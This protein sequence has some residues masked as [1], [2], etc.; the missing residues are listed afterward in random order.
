MQL[1][2]RC[3]GTSFSPHEIHEE[4]PEGELYLR[5]LIVLV[6]GVSRPRLDHQNQHQPCKH[7]LEVSV[8]SGTRAAAGR[9]GS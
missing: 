2:L 1:E 6:L 4:V 7:V 5:L 8:R 9:H 3:H